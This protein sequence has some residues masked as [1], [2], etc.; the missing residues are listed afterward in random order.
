MSGT[1]SPSCCIGFVAVAPSS[2]HH[3]HTAAAAAGWLHTIWKVPQGDLVRSFHRSNERSRFRIRRT[4][5]SR[6]GGGAGRG[7]RNFS[8]CTLLKKVFMSYNAP[9]TAAP[10]SLSL[11]L[12]L[13]LSLRSSLVCLLSYCATSSIGLHY[14]LTFMPPQW[15]NKFSM[16]HGEKGGGEQGIPPAQPVEPTGAAG[17]IHRRNFSDL[18]SSHLLHR[19]ERERERGESSIISLLVLHLPPR[20]RPSRRA[21]P[22]PHVHC[23]YCMLHCFKFVPTLVKRGSDARFPKCFPCPYGVTGVAPYLCRSR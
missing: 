18:L 1:F 4:R 16:P 6:R 17:E 3:D 21:S 10:L 15:H 12:S 13:Y 23:S 9:P 20:F 19:R 2:A 11:S 7:R 14:P 5:R 22:P 8:H